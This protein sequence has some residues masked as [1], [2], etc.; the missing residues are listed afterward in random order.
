MFEIK[1][2]YAAVLGLTGII[3]GAWYML[4]LVRQIMYG[5][6]RKSR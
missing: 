1:P 2:V 5:P 6:L 4:G 3:L